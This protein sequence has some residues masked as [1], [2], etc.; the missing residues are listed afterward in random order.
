VIRLTGMHLLVM[1]LAGIFLATPPA[2]VSA[3][4]E[5]GFDLDSFEKRTLEWGGYIEAR[6]EHAD[7]NQ[8]GA[9]NILNLYREPRSTISSLSSALQLDGSFSKGTTSFN[10]LLQATGAQSDLEWTDKADIFEGYAAI[11]A[12]PNLSIDLGKKSF[13]WGKGYAW[14]PVGFVDRAKDPN[15]PEEAM[16]GY[17][18]A[19]F[20]LVKSYGG[21]LHTVALTTIALPV[22]Q[23]MNEDFGEQD[24]VNLAA[25]LYM[26]YK[27]TDI[28]LVWYTGNS[29]ST[30]YGIDFSRN[31]TTNFEIHGELA[32]VPRQK[33]RV[34]TEAGQLG[35][36]EVSDT[37]YLLGLRYLTENDI[38]AIVEFYHND[39]GYTEQ[40]TTRFFQLLD[41]AYNQFLASGSET[42]LQQAALISESGYARPQTGRDYLYA[43][44]TMKEPFDL[45]YFNPGITSI[46]NLD[47]RS[48]S[49]SPELVY[50]GFTNWE[51]RLR[52]SYLN[53]STDSEYGEKL[54]SN[55]LEFRLR[56]FF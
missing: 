44:I 51:M 46:V 10:W 1:L 7:L 9:F 17:L 29:R 21:D 6:G 15:N 13:K 14:N 33:Y 55:K 22:W 54:N 3:E 45:L 27:D 38:T 24:K 20:D 42:L 40:E 43:R 31:L 28:D 16:E 39:D 2:L 11:K 18:G 12:T 8:D 56:Y 41:A 50:T 34:L 5:Y 49:M 32:H 30:R 25:K 4:E 52:L 36:K 26:L 53:G 48:Y 35:A 47:D 19:G 23:G 37:S